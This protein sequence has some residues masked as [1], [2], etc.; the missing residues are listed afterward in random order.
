MDGLAAYKI[1]SGSD[2]DGA[3]IAGVSVIKAA[4]AII[5]K[6]GVAETRVIKVDVAEI[7]AARVIPRTEGL[8]E[9]KREPTDSATEA[10]SETA[11]K[12]SYERRSVDG[13]SVIRTGAPT[14]AAADIGPTSIVKRSE[15]PR[16][17]TDPRPS[18]RSY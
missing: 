14:P 2:G 1:V 7:Y 17:I 5:H 3:R 10:E 8:T 16:L 11:A 13:P 9:T 12:K 6:G 15:T 4:A 18:P